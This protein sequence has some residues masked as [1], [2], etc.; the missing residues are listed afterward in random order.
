MTWALLPFLAAAPPP[1]CR[2]P[3]PD[4][5]VQV[6]FAPGATLDDLDRF[7]AEVLCQPRGA[8]GKT[9]LPL[10]IDGAVF[11]RQLPALIRLIA[12]AAAAPPPAAVEPSTPPCPGGPAGAIIP[13]DPWTR[14]ISAAVRDQ[15]PACAAGVVRFVPY[16][17]AGKPAGVKLFG[18]RAGSL[19]DQLGLQNGDV[20]AG[21]NGLPLN[22]AE[23]A[24]E[25]YARLKDAPA[26]KLLVTRKGEARTIAWLAQ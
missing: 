4:A 13:V 1:A 25:A 16:V 26:L 2:P 21:V 7:A 20:V 14:K 19:P 22:S 18:I 12:E 23:Q 6:R 3:A 15:L 10:S 24:L 9:P 8:G 17:V 11:G 5:V